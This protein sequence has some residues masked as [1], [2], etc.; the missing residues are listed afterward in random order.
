MHIH[1]FGDLTEGCKSAGSH[2]NPHAKTHGGRKDV[3]RHVGDLG[4]LQTDR[5][6]AAE[7]CIIDQMTTLYG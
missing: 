5:K 6:G 7:M 2:Y 3:N 1:E 4:N